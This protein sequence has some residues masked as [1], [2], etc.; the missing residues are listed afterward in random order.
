ML[1]RLC[2][3]VM[4]NIYIGLLISLL[5]NPNRSAHLRSYPPA[6]VSLLLVHPFEY[7]ASSIALTRV[8]GHLKT[9]LLAQAI[10]LCAQTSRCKV[11]ST[12]G[13][14]LRM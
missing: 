8:G 3:A 14:L 9:G 11:S 12:R 7:N 13:A 1:Q 6:C 2:A 4:R 5:E 10:S